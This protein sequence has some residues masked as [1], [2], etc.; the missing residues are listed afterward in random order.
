MNKKYILLSIS[1]LVLFVSLFSNVSATSWVCYFTWI[2]H[3]SNRICFA[4]TSSSGVT[5]WFAFEPNSTWN[6]LT[7]QNYAQSMP[8]HIVK[9]STWYNVVLNNRS[10]FAFSWYLYW[11]DFDWLIGATGA[12]GPIGATGPSGPIGATGATGNTWLSAFDLA[13]ANGFSGSEVQWVLSL[14]WSGANIYYTNTWTSTVFVTLASDTGSFVPPTDSGSYMPFQYEKNG[15]KYL[16]IGALMY[17]LVFGSLAVA[18]TYFIFR[19]LKSLIS[20][21]RFY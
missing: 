2:T 7:A 19:F 4:P 11:S 21:K 1:G 18:I 9:S 17:L 10:W 5:Y 15:V 12:T 3:L 16:D 6:G 20:W 8:I 14:Q 13:V